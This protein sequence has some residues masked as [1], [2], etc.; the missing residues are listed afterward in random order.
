MARGLGLRESTVE[1][2]DVGSSRVRL[3]AYLEHTR[4]R[5]QPIRSDVTPAD[6]E[7]VGAVEFEI[8][9]THGDAADVDA[10]LAAAPGSG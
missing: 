5:R 8:A 1:D 2:L 10:E 9:A 4:P 3:E 7:T 6:D